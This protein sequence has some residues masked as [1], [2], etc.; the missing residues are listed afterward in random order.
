M[1]RINQ[2]QLELLLAEMKR[3]NLDEVEIA[4]DNG[5]GMN[6]NQSIKFRDINWCGRWNKEHNDDY[7][8]LTLQEYNTYIDVSGSCIKMVK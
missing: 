5:Y 8:L 7:N 1:L 3:Q 4:Y 6:Y 2:T